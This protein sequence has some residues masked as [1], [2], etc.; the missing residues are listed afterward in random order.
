[1]KVKRVLLIID[2][3]KTTGVKRN[4]PD[5][6]GYLVML[7]ISLESSGKPGP[8]ETD[9]SFLQLTVLTGHLLVC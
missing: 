7:L 5:K 6:L 1:M 8:S 4:C 2:C 9:K 3:I